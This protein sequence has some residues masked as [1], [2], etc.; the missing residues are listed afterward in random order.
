[1]DDLCN[2]RHTLAIGVSEQLHDG[3]VHPH[4]ARPR[5]H[6][7]GGR[8]LSEAMTFSKGGLVYILSF[9]SGADRGSC[10][11]SFWEAYRRQLNE[12]V[13]FWSNAFGV[14]T[15]S[16]YFNDCNGRGKR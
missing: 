5:R 16:F 15:W 14:G 2:T 8:P 6:C 9:G 11:N 3:R 7:A 4:F 10:I 12:K 13:I 1:L